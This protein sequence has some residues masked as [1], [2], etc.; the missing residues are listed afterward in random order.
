MPE[1]LAVG[2]LVDRGT[3]FGGHQRRLKPSVMAQVMSSPYHPAAGFGL[4]S[5][6][7]QD[8]ATSCNQI[9][10]AS[11]SS[12]AR[13][14]DNDTAFRTAENSAAVEQHA[15]TALAVPRPSQEAE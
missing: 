7:D 3:G 2:R 10:R 4:L 1:T 12:V 11:Q 5:V 14:A 13:S 15:V 6:V 9:D 8:A